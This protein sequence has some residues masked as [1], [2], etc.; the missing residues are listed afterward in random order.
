MNAKI[1]VIWYLCLW[2][3]SHLNFWKIMIKWVR[4]L[5]MFFLFFI[6]YFWHIL[7]ICLDILELRI[8]NKSE[9][10]V[11]TV[12]IIWYQIKKNW[13]NFL[14]FFIF[15][16]YLKN[17]GLKADQFRQWH[18]L[19]HNLR[20]FLET[21]ELRIENKNF[22]LWKTVFKCGPRFVNT[23]LICPYHHSK[24][25]KK[26]IFFSSSFFT[27]SLFLPVTLKLAHFAPL[28][29]AGRIFPVNI[30]YPR[31]LKTLKW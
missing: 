7:H 13:W 26:M 14:Y 15:F 16:L 1:M 27:S 28:N 18:N 2:P 22:I 5:L 10:S 29:G 30:N 23:K 20:L 4:F 12:L 31:C 11:K 19:W 6:F 3:F 24:K 17:I 21:L 25:Y 9:K 8:E